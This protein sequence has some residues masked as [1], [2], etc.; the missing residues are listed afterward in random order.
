MLVDRICKRCGGPFKTKASNVKRGW[1]LYC[2][3][4]CKA[5]VQTW[6]ENGRWRKAR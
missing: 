4:S 5:D 1:G 2:S 6:K 3:K